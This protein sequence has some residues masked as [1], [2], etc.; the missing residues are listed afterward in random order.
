M[1]PTPL[2]E[3]TTGLATGDKTTR[4]RTQNYY[5]GAGQAPKETRMVFEIASREYHSY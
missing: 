5:R 1:K 3:Q 4:T 2:P